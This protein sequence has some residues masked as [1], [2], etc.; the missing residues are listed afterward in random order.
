MKS[1]LFS[2]ILGAALAACIL[3][4]AAGQQTP[5]QRKRLL[6]IGAVEGFQHDATSHGMATL[7][8]LGQDSGLWETYFKT[9]VQLLTKKKLTANAKNLDYFDAVAFYTTG[10]LKMDD[11]QKAAL[12]SFI[13][14][15]GKGFIGV[16]SAPDTFYKWPEYGEMLG[17]YFDGHPWNTFKAPILVE[18]PSHPIVKHFPREF[19]V[20]DEIYQAKDY[21]REKCRVLLRMDENKLDMTKKGIK[22]ADKDFAIAWVKEYGKGRVFYS[23]LG[24]TEE[25]W[26]D[27][28]VQKMWLEAVKWAMKLTDGTAQPRPRP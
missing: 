21:S 11:E 13:K 27:P 19:A 22:R 18:D 14:D 26:N 7:W 1:P 2:A 12:M 25:S 5:P 3:A 28:N 8:K 15:D 4:P 9:D 17:G 20:L 6:V 23:T 24:H 10:E 16:H